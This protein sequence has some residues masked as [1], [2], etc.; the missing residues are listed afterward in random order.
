MTSDD[1]VKIPSSRNGNF[2]SD[3]LNTIGALCCLIRM[4]LVPGVP[5]ATTT[6]LAPL[7]SH[8]SGLLD[9]PSHA[10]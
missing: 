5:A 10:D 6:R 7:G 8:L 4:Q 3:I 9:L 2:F 1:S